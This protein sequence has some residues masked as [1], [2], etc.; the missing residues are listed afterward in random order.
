LP[1]QCTGAYWLPNPS[2]VNLAAARPS[3]LLQINLQYDRT[4]L[5]VDDQLKCT[6]N[7]RNN[8]AQMINMAIV[9]LGIPPGFDVDTT[10]FEAMRQAGRIAKFELT[11][12]QAI[13]YLRELSDTVPFQ[14][15]YSLRAKYPLR[16]Q[17][18]PSAVYEYYQPRNRAESKAMVL[19]VAGLP[20]QP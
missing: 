1:V 19:Q 20:A 12:N 5:A 4:T 14:F 2:S 6:V 15:D 13:L 9:D 11:G 18:P 16:V 8:T 10:S 3:D 7:V 17:T